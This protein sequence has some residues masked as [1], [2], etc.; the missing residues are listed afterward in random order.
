M[1][2]PVLLRIVCHKEIKEAFSGIVW[3]KSHVEPICFAPRQQGEENMCIMAGHVDVQWPS[4]Q[5]RR[6]T[7]KIM[8]PHFGEISIGYDDGTIVFAHDGTRY[9]FHTGY[10][11]AMEHPQ[12]CAYV[13]NIASAIMGGLKEPSTMPLI[14]E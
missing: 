14:L 1:P 6:I 8:V 9:S 12:K 3:L 7:E 4:D 5:W 11:D 2:M 10:T 13:R